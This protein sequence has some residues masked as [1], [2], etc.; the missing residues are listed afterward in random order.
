MKKLFLLLLFVCG[1]A[2]A[3]IV[4]VPDVNFKNKLIA[5]GIDTNSDGDIQASEALAVTNL[6]VDDSNISDLTG[7]S[8]FVNLTILYCSR[9]QISDLNLSGLNSLQTLYCG[10][11]PLSSINVSGLTNLGLLN[12]DDNQL[13]TLDVS[14]LSNLQFLRCQNGQIANLNLTGAVAL[15]EIYCDHNN[16]SVLNLPVLPS[17]RFLFLSDNNLTSLDLTNCVNLVSVGCPE[18][19]ISNLNVSGLIHLQSLH[20]GE[21]QLTSLDLSNLPELQYIACGY[22]QLTSLDLSGLSELTNVECMNNQ[23]TVLNLNDQVN[24]NSFFVQNNNL[25]TFYIKN[26]KLIPSMDPLI[27]DFSNNPN[28]TF[29][30]TE[31]Y[32][33]EVFVDGANSYGLTNVVVSSYCSFTPGGNYNTITGSVIFDADNNGCDASDLPQS[34]IKVEIGSP[35]EIGATYTNSSGNYAF[36]TQAGNF[37]VMPDIENPSFFNF[38]PVNAMISFPDNNNNVATQNFCL[39]ANGVHP[40]LEVVVLP[41][42]PARPGQDAYYTI[43][44]KNKGNQLMSQLYGVTFSFNNNLMNLV[45]TSVPTSS[46]TPGT[47]TW[48]YANLM[49]FESRRIEVVMHINTPTD[50]NP[51]NSGDILQLTA[52]ISPM[53]GDENVMDNTFQYNQTVLNSYDPNDKICLEGETESPTKIGDYLHYVI[54]FENIG[55]ADAINV[56]V[57][58]VID[59]AKYDEKSLQ[60]LNSSHPVTAK[61]SGNVAE[62]IFEN[63]NLARGGHGNILL[64]VKTKDNLVVGDVVSNKADI[65]FDYNAPIQTNMASTRFESLGIVDTMVD[66]L[67]SIYPNPTNDM[68]HVKSQ[69]AIQ[70]LQLF[71]VQGRL[72]QTRIS[73]NQNETI[74]LTSKASG[75]YF[76]KIATEKGAKIEKVIKK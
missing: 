67:I 27:N 44:Y 61:I 62:F 51:V 46:Q 54:N 48:D 65:F 31:D 49:P 55:T 13:T 32:N 64:K 29:I 39:T 18:N 23:L 28:L 22:N 53:L 36:Y 19:Q 74:D 34:F 73:E 72:L 38:S 11:N 12:C 75:V 6:V 7:I 57:K 26:G 66:N 45:S 2:Q 25:N 17:L 8:S 41:T 20:A 40:D 21:N 24:L 56:V 63:I 69:S 14:G 68:I 47:L 71:D 59:M 50:A 4:N 30:C 15:D 52:T 43:V 5:L 35:I 3:Q 33:I 42:V 1:F 9:N 60:I 37:M 16:L 70:S 76:V 10:S 58:D